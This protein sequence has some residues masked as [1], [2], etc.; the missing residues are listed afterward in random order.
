MKIIRKV[1]S[2]LLFIGM[3]ALVIMM[4]FV[5]IDIVARYIFSKPIAGSSEPTTTNERQPLD[6]GV[7][8]H[9]LRTFDRQGLVGGQ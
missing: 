4:V 5:C 9:L 7:G 1:S 2:V 8:D 6:V 3:S